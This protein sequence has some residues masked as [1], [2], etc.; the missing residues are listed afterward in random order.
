MPTP[1]IGAAQHP[2]PSGN[3]PTVLIALSHPS[4]EPPLPSRAHY[5]LSPPELRAP[6]QPLTRK[7]GVFTH[8]KPSRAI[9]FMSGHRNRESPSEGATE[10]GVNRR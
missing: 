3:R 2:E 7:E 6:T 4:S 5:G 1:R 9:D 10:S 8:A